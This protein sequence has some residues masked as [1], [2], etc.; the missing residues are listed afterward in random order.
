[1]TA[2]LGSRLLGHRALSVLAAPGVWPMA[3][4]AAA[5]ATAEV[6]L[7]AQLPDFK[8][9]QAALEMGRFSEAL[10]A[11]RRAVDVAEAYFPPEA[12]WERALCHSACGRCLWFTGQFAEA[13]AQFEAGAKV[14]VGHAVAGKSA[15]AAAQLAGAAARA[16]FEADHFDAAERLANEAVASAPGAADAPAGVAMPLLVSEAL[17]VVRGGELE[18]LQA[19]GEPT[20]RATAESVAARRLNRLVGLTV[21]DAFAGALV[22]ET[23]SILWGAAEAMEAE[24]GEGGALAR[25]L[26]SEGEAASPLI[27]ALRATA[28]ELAVL[29]GQGGKPW[30]RPLLVA[31]LKDFEALHPTGPTMVPVR[32]RA[33]GALG[34]LT[35]LVQGDAITAEGLFRSAVDHIDEAMR[36]SL[37]VGLDGGRGRLWRALVFHGF[38]DFL[39]RTLRGEQRASEIASLRQR[40]VEAMVSEEIAPRPSG[41]RLRW[42]LV[43][44]PP[45]QR[46]L[47]EEVFC[48]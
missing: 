4:R 15:A 18:P 38:A 25:L 12:A 42:A 32:F 9:G 36:T 39:E 11:F 14:V 5:A 44:L 27:M 33:L 29:A 23:P 26:Q 35:G 46:V 16:H 17:R 6:G 47:I 30:A 21:P 41:S 10:L 24:L 3:R 40:A 45:P 28:G 22:P 8:E 37:H 34:T 19:V 1:M 2:A 13:G 43:C 31:A 48:E 20:D 7:L